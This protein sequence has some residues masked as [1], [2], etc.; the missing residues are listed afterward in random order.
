[1]KR[2]L[3]YGLCMLS[4]MLVIGMVIPVG[5]LAQKTIKIGAIYPL[6]GGAARSSR[7]AAAAPPVRG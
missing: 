5:A 6:T 3:K 7:P 4:L 2:A 1:M